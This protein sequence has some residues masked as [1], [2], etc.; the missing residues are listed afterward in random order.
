MT[1]WTQANSSNHE[2]V[3]P[4]VVEEVIEDSNGKTV[5]TCEGK[6]GEVE[7]GGEAF[8]VKVS[9]GS[10]LAC[11]QDETGLSIT[12]HSPHPVCLSAAAVHT[13]ARHDIFN[14]Q[15]NLL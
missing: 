2:H 4:I 15:Q 13:H 14:Q 11:T 6:L 9:Y 3:V 8:I 10:A 7:P 5:C 12:V 1:H